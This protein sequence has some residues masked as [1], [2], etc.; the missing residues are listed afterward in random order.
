M[1][2][3]LG[4]EEETK[5]H[6]RDKGEEH[7]GFQPRRLPYG[8]MD[9]AHIL[10]EKPWPQAHRRGGHVLDQERPKNQAAGGMGSPDP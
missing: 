1:Q 4:Q 5:R 8:R 9:P 2:P 10:L 3:R 7:Q 6:E